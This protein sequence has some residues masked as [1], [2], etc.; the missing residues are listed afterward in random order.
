MRELYAD[1]RG[2]FYFLC[3]YLRVLCVSALNS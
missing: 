2:L 1:A 3:A